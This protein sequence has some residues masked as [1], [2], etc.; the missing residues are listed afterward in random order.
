MPESPSP[1]SVS[2]I[3]AYYDKDWSI[4]NF[5]PVEVAR[6]KNIYK[7]SQHIVDGFLPNQIELHDLSDPVGPGVLPDRL[8]MNIDTI[9]E[10]GGE[11]AFQGILGHE[12]AHRYYD[13]NEVFGALA[14]IYEVQHGI[15]DVHTVFIESPEAFAGLIVKRFGSI[16]DF[17]IGMQNAQ[18]RTSEVRQIFTD[19]GVAPKTDP[20]PLADRLL[21]DLKTQDQLS[22]IKTVFSEHDYWNNK[23]DPMYSL[24]FNFYRKSISAQHEDARIEGVPPS[25]YVIDYA[26]FLPADQ[27][28]RSAIIG[29]AVQVY[30]QHVAPALSNFHELE[31]IDPVIRKALEHRADAYMTEKFGIKIGLKVLTKLL[32]DRNNMSEEDRKGCENEGSHPHPQDRVNFV[33]ERYRSAQPSALL[34]LQNENLVPPSHLATGRSRLTI[35][36]K[37]GYSTDVAKEQPTGEVS[38]APNPPKVSR[39][40]S[41]ECV[42]A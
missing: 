5:N 7:S 1:G 4:D 6:V 13:D 18:Q 8:R 12:A 16:E 37:G 25:D 26:S 34:Q 11:D 27:A 9:D 40:A 15:E 42:P 41:T 33:Q 29:R 24:Y 2:F 19:M 14:R 39:A 17:A 35:L 32:K 36:N 10:W 22:Q 38:V 28:E 21:A 20:A 3:G 23:K 30:D 31:A